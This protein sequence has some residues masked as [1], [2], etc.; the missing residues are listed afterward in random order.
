M[1]KI[2]FIG[3]GNMNSAII[4]G[5]IKNGYNPENII[6]SNP[7]EAKRST[8]AK[9]LGIHQTADNEH[10]TN[11]ADVI[12]LGVKPHFITEVC[13][14]I[15]KNIDVSQK[16]F[17][18]VAA[19]CT[20]AQIE[21]ALG[22]QCAVIRTMPNTPAQLGH[23]VTGIFAST[24]VSEQQKLFTQ[25]LMSSVGIIKWLD[26]EEQIGHITAI[27]GSGPAYFFLFMEAMQKQAQA[28]GFSEQ[29]SRELV[30]QTA[31][32]AA[33]MVIDNQLPISTLREKVTSKGGTTQ[34][35]ISAFGEGGLEQ[36]VTK[37]MNCALDRAKEMAKNS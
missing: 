29:D 23:G 37:A 20:I 7:S 27:S 30:Q 36:L 24:Q 12:V 31:L 1:N 4:S 6:V 28:Y 17:I 22:Q 32:G 33:K 34:A 21:Q 16:C 18:S 9:Q 26:N 13:E 19:G 8:L 25:S 10:A 5:L 11:F 3:A 35:A 2:A 14:K 15:G